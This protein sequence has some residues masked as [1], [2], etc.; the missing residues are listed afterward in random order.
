MKNTH[1][2]DDLKHYQSEAKQFFTAQLWMLKTVIPMIADDRIGKTATLLLSAGHT[3]SALLELSDRTE[4]FAG[5]Q[6]MLARSFLEKVTNFIYASIC[7]EKE[8]RAFILHPIYKHYHIAGSHSLADGFDGYTPEKIAIR[9]AKQDSLKKI[10]IVQEALSM[11]SET[12]TNLRWTKTNMDQR[13]DAISKWGKLLDPF[14]FLC[15]AEYYSDASEALHG[16]L[17]GCTFDTGVLA[18]DYA[19]AMEEPDGINK[20]LYKDSACVMLHLGMLIHESFTLIKYSSDIDELWK[21]SY[22]NRGHALNL[23]LHVLQVTSPDK[24]TQ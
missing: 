15:K 3:G 14:F 24:R 13:I 18:P 9:K 6:V 22:D 17:Y 4:S 10:P 11:F 1:T 16:S 19:H 12:K 2:L 20:K 23:L 8:Y 21:H 5:E 7:D